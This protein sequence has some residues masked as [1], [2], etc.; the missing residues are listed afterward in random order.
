[1]VANVSVKTENEKN[2][3]H[4]DSIKQNEIQSLA[5][6]ASGAYALS[7]ET[8]QEMV[9]AH[10]FS[11]LRI[12]C[13]KEWSGLRVHVVLNYLQEL[14]VREQR[15][16][17]SSDYRFLADDQTTSMSWVTSHNFKKFYDFFGI[18]GTLYEHAFFVP[19]QYHIIIWNYP[20]WSKLRME[21]GD[22]VD[23]SGFTSVGYWEFYVR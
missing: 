21:C 6:V 8:L 15:S 2:Q 3:R 22:F 1:M 5:N 12:K 18:R 10:G 20:L 19:S 17:T 7:L 4:Y 16:L 9:N 11:E 13:F 14:F 23:Q